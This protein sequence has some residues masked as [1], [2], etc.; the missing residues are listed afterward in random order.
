MKKINLFIIATLICSIS[1]AQ[2]KEIVVNINHLYNNEVVNFDSTYLV[3][4]DI[5]IKFDRIEYYIHCNNLLSNLNIATYFSDK[6]LLVNA[7]QNIYNLGEIELIDDNITS[8]NFNIGVA[9]NLNH[10]D[11]SQWETS[12]PLAPKIPSM[13]WGW[14]AGYRFVALEGMIDKNQDNVLE[15][16]FQYHPVDDSYYSDTITFN[17]IV[18]S[19]DNITIFINAN[20]NKLIE[21]IGTDQ[22]GVYH[23]VHYENRL[24]I[25]NMVNNQVFTTP[26]NLH[27][28]HISNLDNIFPNPFSD[29]IYINLNENSKINIYNSIGSLELS[30]ELNEGNHYI[31]TEGL[32]NG[33]YI[34][35]IRNKS[36][37]KYK[38]MLKK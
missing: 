5:P 16:V 11:P 10:A 35:C 32:K 18:E 4:E 19:N 15:T 14:A 37:I 9:S 1:Q 12:H 24:L 30:Y 33:I 2:N 21:N 13:H 31:N 26:N 8:F 28:N 36:G 20:Y 38:K 27:V 23:G 7:S 6:Y 3:G 17:G 22:G 29:L 34:I 25:D